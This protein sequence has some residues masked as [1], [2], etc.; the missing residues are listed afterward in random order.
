MKNNHSDTGQSIDTSAPLKI[1][2][3]PFTDW[4]EAKVQCGGSFGQEDWLSRI[5]EQLISY[6]AEIAQF[7]S[8]HPPRPCSLAVV[9]SVI[10][11]KSIIDFGGS[12]GWAWEY[13]KN[14]LPVNNIN[15]Y[16][17]IEIEEIIDYMQRSALHEELVKFK[18]VNDVTNSVD[19]IYSNSALQYLESNSTLCA[20]VNKVS[21]KYILLDD[22]T[23]TERLYD[24]YALQKF[25]NQKIPY[26]FISFSLLVSDMM[27]LG[28]QL[29]Y[30]SPYYSPVD[31]VIKKLPMDN[32]P[33]EFQVQHTLS[34]LF[35]KIDIL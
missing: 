25:Y 11:P 15:T 29:Q 7:G 34:A 21:P 19:L 33:K 23:S 3:G 24:F 14:S 5:A 6:R 12:S 32:F 1:W 30:K 17:I 35:K 2:E 8:T 20:L 26:R 28:Y 18:S 10:E 4:A 9:S 16:E 13:L 27:R 31:G 22:L